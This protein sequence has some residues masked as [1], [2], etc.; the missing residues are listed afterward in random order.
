MFCSCKNCQFENF[1]KDEKSLGTVYIKNDNGD[2]YCIFH[3][4]QKL[5]ENFRIV[6]LE[7]FKELIFK[8][9]SFVQ[10]NK[11]LFYI[12]FSHV[13]F[14][15]TT[16]L[17]KK[18]EFLDLEGYTLDFSYA[19][20][21]NNIRFDNLKCKSIIFQDTNFLDGGGLKNKNGDKNLKIKELIFKPY[22]IESDFVIDIGKYAKNDTSIIQHREGIIEKIE[23]ENHKKGDGYVFFIG[24]NQHTLE[25]HFENRLLDKV[26]FQNC[27]L[28]NC[29][30]L[31]AK[32]ED[33]EFRNCTFPKNKNKVNNLE[34]FSKNDTVAK[35]LLPLMM[36]FYMWYFLDNIENSDLLS[37][38]V[39][40]IFFPVFVMVSLASLDHI[41]ELILGFTKIFQQEHYCIADE[42][43]IYKQLNRKPDN[44]NITTLQITLESLS[45]SY[46]QL[47]N[48]FKDK[49]FQLAGDFFYSQRY[50]E[51]LVGYKGTKKSVI[52]MYLYNI[53]HFTNGFGESF[54]RPMVWFSMT[55]GIFILLYSM[56]AKANIDYI[57]T[58]DTPL[59]LIEDTKTILNKDT[60]ST[61]ILF[62]KNQSFIK[63]V[64]IEHNNTHI[65]NIKKVYSYNRKGNYEF[66]EEYILKL[67][68][69]INTAV[70]K[71][72]SNIIYPFSL[73]TKK[74]FQDISKKAYLLS[75][76]ETMLL[77]YFTGAF[78]LA[79]W[80]RIRR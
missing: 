18:Q 36:L 26:Y 15:H 57:S 17:E 58:P 35:F 39:I 21:I 61:T 66:Y 28:S 56:F 27:D 70:F 13:V 50:T 65:N 47:K 48:N 64:E 73:G 52:D 14:T 4:P 32:I 38:V 25:A 11:T 51:L 10:K 59:F 16:F 74:W 31:N 19:V 12:D 7:Y 23:F 9:I 6:Q 44:L 69:N 2:Q 8:Y 22:S 43:K 30:F 55:L 68:N 63:I 37:I 77:W 80:H 46:S 24:I 76:L 54:L 33:T 53:H 71:S 60:N 34:F 1:L 45:A 75:I 49:D 62:K 3:A 29:Y 67:K 5:K 79:I 42:K 72:L 41:L 20:F 40:V 78:A